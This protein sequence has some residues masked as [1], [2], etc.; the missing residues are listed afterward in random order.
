MLLLPLTLLAVLVGAPSA[1]AQSAGFPEARQVD[2]QRS[3]EDALELSRT[4]ERPLLVA[5]N[6]DGESASERIVRERYRDPEWVAQTRSFVCV[7]ASVFRHSPR[8]HADNGERIPCPRFGEVT[9]AE[10][11]ALEPATHARWLAGKVIELF[12]ETTERISPRHVLVSPQGE[13]LFDRYLLFEL[14]E[15]DAELARW[16][17]RL[18]PRPCPDPRAWDGAGSFDPS[19]RARLATENALAAGDRRLRAV[20]ER[21]RSTRSPT[22]R[23]MGEWL[24]RLGPAL[25]PS[26]GP[27]EL[28]EL[29]FVLS[30][31]HGELESARAWLAALVQAGGAAR[32]AALGAFARVGAGRVADRTLFRSFVGLGSQ[33]EL[34]AARQAIASVEGEWTAER[35][36]S[37]DLGAGGFSL[38]AYFSRLA[39]ASPQPSRRV[40]ERPALPAGEEAEAQLI[41]LEPLLRFD[42][43]SV[44]QHAQAGRALLALARRRMS[45][46]AG[47]GVELM[48]SDAREHLAFASAAAP[49]DV[50]LLL[51]SA[52]TANLLTRF[53]EQEHFA[54]QA[55]S[56]RATGGDGG[57]SS[58]NAES[59]RWLGDACARR[60]A[61][62]SGADGL[63]EM[64]A[65]TRGAA[66][67]ALAAESDDADDG[68][69]VSLASYFGALG[70]TAESEKLACEGLRRFPASAALWTQLYNACA[71]RGRHARYAELAE[72]LADAA[73]DWPEPRW[74]AGQARLWLA[75]WDRR[76]EAPERANDNYARAKQHFARALELAPHFRESC[77]HY[78]AMCALGRGFAHLMADRRAEAAECVVEAAR[79]RPQALAQRDGLDREGVDLI[80]GVLELRASGRTPVDSAAWLADL[81]RADPGNAFWA[82]SIGDAQLREAIRAYE[83]QQLELGDWHMQR[84][85]S[86]A[87][88]ARRLEAGDE[89][90][91][92]LAQALTVLAERLAAHAG[93]FLQQRQ[94]LSEAA[95]VIGLPAPIGDSPD[96][97]DELRKLLRARLGPAR[98][99][100]RAGR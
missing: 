16:A 31:P 89:S 25:G 37:S 65:L 39:R 45:E 50:D 52:R 58:A 98:P 51:D 73:P 26:F 14:S 18:P 9:C 3:L 44:L 23:G 93:P 32:V 11:I 46:G 85:I 35:V 84:G 76:G 86:A 68:D 60:L 48:L 66:A 63:D 17:T 20:L 75:Q 12:G 8:D 36:R 4:L 87:R 38:A 79:I 94:A 77:E 92:A 15:L 80:D 81:E 91:A 29:A 70:R 64:V 61:E 55:L 56:A 62:R 95:Q 22:P 5:I 90:D 69:W 74:Y 53:D 7:V 82:R 97:W 1:H 67:F 100:F 57:F 2:W 34:A 33:E 99:V 59:L 24:W 71:S 19:A 6:A 96:V 72:Q 28:A 88:S 49:A 78:L 27:S 41:A 21:V 40:R 13:V 43:A 10:H 42:G 83:R 47:A 54:L 30:A